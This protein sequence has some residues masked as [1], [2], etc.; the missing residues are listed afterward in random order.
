MTY[1]FADT[2]YWLAIPLPRDAL[3]ERAKRAGEE[4]LR[5][6]RIVTSELVVVEV[7]NFLHAHSIELRRKAYSIFESLPSTRLVEIVPS[8]RSLFTRAGALYLAAEDKEWSFTDCSSF[9][10]MRERKI[11]NVLTADHHFEQAGFRALL[12]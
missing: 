4:Y 1:I 9:A 3:H 7:L 12:K 10:I 2:S 11:T 6:A 8:A 5:D